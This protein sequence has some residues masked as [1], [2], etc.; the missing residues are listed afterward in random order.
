MAFVFSSMSGT[1]GITTITL[2]ADENL[3]FNTIFS[4]YT[5]QNAKRQLYMG[6]LQ[7]QYVPS[8]DY[9]F[10]KPT[11][12][13]YGNNGG[14][15]SLKVI[16]NQNWVIKCSD[17]I[18]INGM[19]E[20]SGYGER[21]L[22][23]NVNPNTGSTIRNGYISG[24]C[25][26]DSSITAST[27]VEQE[28]SKAFI[29]VSPSSFTV[30]GSGTSSNTISVSAN[31][32]Y[33]I[34][35][36]AEWI[37][38]DALSGS[39]VGSVSFST[40]SHTG[41]T[42][43]G[44]ITFTS[45]QLTE[46]VDVERLQNGIYLYADLSSIGVDMS[47]ETIEVS[48]YSSVD[49]VVTNSDWF[50]VSPSSGNGNGTLMIVVSSS[51][52]QRDGYIELTN[53]QYGLTYTIEVIQS[54]GNVILYSASHKENPNTNTFG[55][56]TIVSHTFNNGSGVI[57]FDKTLRTIP[58]RAFSSGL[59]TKDY[60]TIYLPYTVREIGEFAFS[61]CSELWAVDLPPR[62]NPCDLY[63]TFSKCSELSGEDNGGIGLLW[64][65]NLIPYGV[66]AA[67]NTYYECRGVQKVTIPNTVETLD[68][69]FAY[70]D[71]RDITIPNSVKS[72]NTTF[73]DCKNLESIVIPDSV[74]A[75]T[76][77][78]GCTTGAVGKLRDITIPSSV[79]LI[80]GLTFTKQSLTAI[81]IPDTVTVMSGGIF[82]NCSALTAINI[83]S[84]SPL[85]SFDF[86]MNN[87]SALTSIV[88]PKNVT[89]INPSS[90]SMYGNFY[91]SGIRNIYS[92]NTKAPTI[93]SST[94]SGMTASE[95]R[96]H[97]PSGSDYSSWRRITDLLGNRWRYT[98]DL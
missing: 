80:S 62:L 86:S 38:L 16:S 72:L 65:K 49:W 43:I 52:D 63:F 35:T 95:I 11:S 54:I 3:D 40:A 6:V 96:V 55:D 44:S 45:G 83:S 18:G 79:T 22:T 88:I 27:V 56:A 48:V 8:G 1:S 98:G 19:G 84:A 85:T 14:V 76:N 7:K 87:C 59:S 60:Q 51:S 39:G 13:S 57:T 74:T 30:A 69:T 36:N 25:T 75:L 46:S 61:G 23:Y 33:T 77:T 15:G 28:A 67:T 42:D 94:F 29:T 41:A 50:T 92:Y 5:L 31:C 68:S 12:V 26:S 4:A 24:Y 64:S 71:I 66:T 73:Y 93:F 82:D 34:T 70:S 89:S 91:R 47:G 32:D 10:F 9:L 2:T 81:T 90:T 17:W 20:I 53:S 21:I 37:T 97:Y 58:A 78:F